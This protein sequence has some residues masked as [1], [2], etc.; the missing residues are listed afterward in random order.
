MKKILSPLQDTVFNQ[1]NPFAWLDI[2]VFFQRELIYLMQEYGY[3][4]EEYDMFLSW[5][6]PRDLVNKIL[7][8]NRFFRII[9]DKEG[10]II[11]YF[12]SRKK[13]KTTE[14]VQWVLIDKS[15][16]GQWFSKIIWEEFFKYCK[17]QWRT[18]ILSFAKS[19]NKASCH[20][21][22]WLWFKQSD[23][24][25]DDLTFSKIIS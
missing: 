9:R 23:N 7:D 1:D 20:M 18:I 8:P 22:Q 25:H 11:G 15:H 4:K 6:Q 19:Q 13:D 16:R 12:E 21:H 5:H 24:N 14:V 2:A 17:L 10:K 3:T